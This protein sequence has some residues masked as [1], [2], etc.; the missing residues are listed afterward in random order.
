MSSMS[1]GRHALV[2]NCTEQLAQLKTELPIEWFELLSD[3]RKLSAEWQVR[4]NT[5]PLR[6]H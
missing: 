6:I 5:I 4:E 2:G 1:F 3:Y